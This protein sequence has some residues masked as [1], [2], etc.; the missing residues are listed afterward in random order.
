MELCIE[1]WSVG[2][3]RPPPAHAENEAEV[4]Q[5]FNRSN[6]HQTRRT[7]RQAKISIIHRWHSEASLFCRIAVVGKSASIY[8]RTRIRTMT[9]KNE[10]PS[11]EKPEEGKASSPR[12]G[13]LRKISSKKKKHNG[14]NRDLSKAEHANP[15]NRSL[16]NSKHGGQDVETFL[17]EHVKDKSVDILD[18]ISPSNDDNVNVTDL[19]DKK[20]LMSQDSITIEARRTPKPETMAHID[21]E[22]RPHNPVASEL[23][24]T[25][26]DAVDTTIDEVGYETPDDDE[27]PEERTHPIVQSDP[28]CF[29]DPTPVKKKLSIPSATPLTPD[30]HQQQKMDE[31]S[32]RAGMIGTNFSSSSASSPRASSERRLS[33]ER[34]YTVRERHGA[35]WQKLH[36]MFEKGGSV[37]KLFDAPS[38]PRNND[39]YA[40]SKASVGE[41]DSKHIKS[42]KELAEELNSRSPKK[43]EGSPDTTGTTAVGAGTDMRKAP[44]APTL[45]Q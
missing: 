1:P 31:S 32:P 29:S 44:L 2:D 10:E 26:Q 19:S 24:N 30:R 17:A 8:R 39:A 28:A 34:N 23:F 9:K 36:D 35:E 14:S 27:E 6:F 33:A 7:H 4:E 37:P 45:A 40:K 38:S 3:G 21:A 18:D 15:M 11:N 16:P 41:I 42:V 13:F 20:F 22:D 43:A 25:S 5:L 12:F